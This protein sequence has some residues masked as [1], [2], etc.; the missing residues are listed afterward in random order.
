MPKTEHLSLEDYWLLRR[1]QPWTNEADHK[2]GTKC[3]FC[4]P[5]S[6]SRIQNAI[7]FAKSRKLDAYFVLPY[8]PRKK[9]WNDLRP[10]IKDTIL[11]FRWREVLNASKLYI[12]PTTYR[13]CIIH[14]DFSL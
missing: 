11:K 7:S 9:L 6:D 4:P 12:A 14:A 1:W 8:W 3:L 2:K 5:H 10:V 13:G